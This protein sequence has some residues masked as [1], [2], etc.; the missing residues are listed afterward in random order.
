MKK[1][2]AVE[3]LSEAFQTLF[4]NFGYIFKKLWFVI[5]IDIS[6]NLLS[7]LLVKN[8]YELVKYISINYIDHYPFFVYGYIW[9]IP[10]LI[11]TTMSNIAGYTTKYSIEKKINRTGILG[12]R[13]S[14]IEIKVAIATF[15]TLLLSSAFAFIPFIIFEVCDCNLFGLRWATAIAI[16]L[17]FL[18]MYFRIHLIIPLYLFTGKINI[19][20]SWLLTKDHKNVA[21]VYMIINT[22]FLLL[23]GLEIFLKNIINIDF[24]TPLSISK[25]GTMYSIIHFTLCIIP[26]FFAILFT[27]A[28][29]KKLKNIK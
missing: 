6:F 12:V 5:V 26:E 25:F 16:Y 27:M 2:S 1:I 9:V 15:V 23:I 28:F 8:N 11:L 4:H 13:I 3:L 22:A 21:I 17:L 14:K 10:A 19:K 24:N 29:Y 7:S 20:E 18:W